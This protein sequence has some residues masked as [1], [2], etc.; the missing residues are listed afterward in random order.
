MAMDY[1]FHEGVRS[2][3]SLEN[4]RGLLSGDSPLIHAFQ[5]AG[6]VVTMFE[7]A[8]WGSSCGPPVD[9]C[10]RTG[11]I[12]RSLWSLGQVSPLASIQRGLSPHPFALIGLQHIRELGALLDVDSSFPRFVFIPVT[13]PHPPLQLESS[14]DLAIASDRASFAHASPSADA[15]EIEIARERYLNQVR[16]V[17][18]EV[19]ATIDR[20]IAHSDDLAMLIVSD[21]GSESRAQYASSVGEWSDEALIERMAVLSAI[22]VPSDCVAQD[23]SRTTVNT[24]RRFVNCTA[25]ATSATL[26]DYSYTVPLENKL[27]SPIVDVTDRLFSIDNETSR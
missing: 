24:V 10:H 9:V 4:M 11:L 14:C 20:L 15:R 22:R 16:C 5:D 8:W 27:D 12:R 6:F 7:S 3:L 26:P 23:P 21:H 18:R 25:G 17:D 2:E 19:L 13:V 1:S